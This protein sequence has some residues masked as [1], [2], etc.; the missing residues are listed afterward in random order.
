MNTQNIQSHSFFK[1]ILDKRNIYSAIFCMESYIFD[2]G[3]LDT[4]H[5]V[6]LYNESGQVCRTLL[7]DLALYSALADKHNVDLAESVISTCHRRLSQIFK[8]KDELFEIKVYFKLKKFDTDS[9]TPKF[10][11][12]HTA[13]LID[14]ICMVSILNC[15]MYDD[16]Y[17]NGKRNLSDLSKLVPHNFYGNIPSTNVQYLFLKWQTKYKEYTETVIKHGRQYQKDHSFLTEVCL[18]IKNFFPSIS[19]KFLYN[20]I[21]DKCS[22]THSNDL[23]ELKVAVTK[24]LYFKLDRQN[25]EP[26]K[27]D[28]YSIE[29][30]NPNFYMNCGI[31][32][33]LPQSYFFGNLCMIEIKEQL[34]QN[35]CFQGDAYFYVDDSVIYVQSKL[36]KETFLSKIKDLNENMQKWCQEIDKKSIDLDSYIDRKYLDFHK[37]LS[38]DIK[39]HDNDKS[40]FTPIDNIDNQFE[41]VY[42]MS[43]RAS[44]VTKLSWDMDETDDYV[45][46]EKLKALD[47][48]I[49]KEIDKLK[50]LEKSNKESERDFAKTRLKLLRRFKKFFLYRNLKL[51][52]KE[53]GGPNETTIQEFKNHFLNPTITLEEWL[54]HNDENIFQSEYRLLIQ[55]TD[56]KNAEQLYTAIKSW[57]KSKLQE[58]DNQKY[59]YLYYSKDAECA[60][61]MKSLTQDIYATLILWA[62][63]NF[64]GIKNLNPSKQME[65]FRNFISG[66]EDISI[67]TMLKNGYEN[68]KFTQF[69]LKASAEYQRRILNVYFSEIIGVQPTDY[70]TFTKTNSRKCHYTEL[71]I[72][73]YLRNK[74]FKLNDFRV[75]VESVDEN[76]LSN[77]MGIDMGILEVLNLFIKHVRKPEWVDSLICTHRLTKGLWYNGSK[78]LNA[79]TLHNE[80]HA[81]TLI[82]NSLELIHRIDYFVLKKVDYYILFLSCYLHDISMVIHPDLGRM[83]LPEGKN[84]AIV[85]SLMCKMRTEV[86]KFFRIDSNDAKNSRMKDASKFL[87]EIFNEVFGYFENEVRDY[88]AYDSAKFIRENDLLCYIQPTILSFVA[89][90]SESHGYDVYDV[91]GLKSRAKDDTISLKYLMMLIRLS[92]LLDVANDRV[93]YH[94]LHQNLKHLPLISKFHWISHLVTDKI[95]LKTRYIPYDGNTTK[96][97]DNKPI[98]EEIN[99]N[100]WL[101]FQQLT[102]DEVNSHCQNCSCSLENGYIHIK[103]KSEKDNETDNCMQPKCPILCRWMM[104]KHE[105]LIPELVALNDYLFS[106]NDSLIKTT[107][108]FNI[109][110]Q[111]DRKL[112]PDMFSVIQEFLKQPQIP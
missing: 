71:R 26:W 101:N 70:L 67:H 5:P 100:L 40:I 87:I 69:I 37:K 66:K 63:E 28:Y 20:Y 65:K 47:S 78:F 22:V 94:L 74:D 107:I 76:D 7:N 60:Y 45:T 42:A 25:I 33:G 80:E 81:V 88:H 35:D 97:N 29:L 96:E 54:E 55:N 82:N 92:D 16:D 104:K 3:L 99:L 61:Q 38:Y 90:V 31:P 83:S 2:K 46:L 41:L 86:D 10:R 106:V 32:Q 30:G 1:R 11:P 75:F 58:I 15:L 17:D 21:I 44:T 14:L 102:T 91:Y 111:N 64:N 18:D 56:K 49:S 93:N 73:A 62:K 43:R 6:F 95:E 27:N 59:E 36:T 53:T 84:L 110:Y 52:M 108:N 57:E 8:N 89:K 72:L 12:L 34:L 98:I 79:Y 105:W 23:E 103:I 39:F 24:L 13:R 48:V 51:Q 77:S 50:E 112:D 68:K 109:R 4:Q 19:P 9:K 85:S